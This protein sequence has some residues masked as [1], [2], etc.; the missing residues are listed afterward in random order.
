MLD[1]ATAPE[2]SILR[3]SPAPQAPPETRAAAKLEESPQGKK[4][5]LTHRS[6]KNVRLTYLKSLGTRLAIECFKQQSPQV[7]ESIVTMSNPA[8]LTG[9]ISDNTAAIFH[10]NPELKAHMQKRPG[11]C[12]V[13]LHEL[14]TTLANDL[15]V[16]QYLSY[17]RDKTESSFQQLMTLFHNA[18]ALFLL[19]PDYPVSQQVLLASPDLLITHIKN[20]FYKI[21]RQCANIKH[22]IPPEQMLEHIQL[23]EVQAQLKMSLSRLTYRKHYTDEIDI[24]PKHRRDLEYEAGLPSKKANREGRD[25]G[26][27][28]DKGVGWDIFIGDHQSIFE[29]KM[30]DM[31]SAAELM[32][33]SF[34]GDGMA[35]DGHLL[36]QCDLKMTQLVVTNLTNILALGS[37]MAEFVT[38]CRAVLTMEEPS[39]STYI[40][41]C[42]EDIHGLLTEKLEEMD[43]T[44]TN[45][46]DCMNWRGRNHG[47]V[48]RCILY[49][50][51][52][53]N[54]NPVDYLQS[55]L[56]KVDH[57]Y[58]VEQMSMTLNSPSEDTVLESNLAEATERA[59]SLDTG[60]NIS[61]STFPKEEKQLWLRRITESWTS[62]QPINWNQPE[63]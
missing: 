27:D 46:I 2:K 51:R 37:D 7:Q 62:G 43:K 20:N 55:L 5:P 29:S 61:S 16:A 42:G 36:D 31:T 17:L 23:Y 21:F 14:Q 47:D 58:L 50:R 57:E 19:N 52:F 10:E 8:E 26:E 15:L 59:R 28:E 40:Q 35:I 38:D 32:T 30:A 56:N 18:M 63:S 33:L 39:R 12:P 44:A 48:E 45:I 3:K 49:L 22:Y 41:L 25:S 9:F 1:H 34:W 54:E 6:V 4:K 24:R 11:E 13:N 60:K 53:Y